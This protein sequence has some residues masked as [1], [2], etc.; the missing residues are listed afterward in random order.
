M[1]LRGIYDL[2]SV[3][4]SSEDSPAAKVTSIGMCLHLQTKCELNYPFH[5]LVANLRRLHNLHRILNP[6]RWLDGCLLRF[7]YRKTMFASV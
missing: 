3:A 1:T 6:R 5:V 2:L 7:D 4:A